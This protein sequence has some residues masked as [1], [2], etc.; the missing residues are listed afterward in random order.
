MIQ[1][2]YL[3]TRQAEFS[4]SNAARIAT[5]PFVAKKKSF[6]DLMANEHCV[7]CFLVLHAY[8]THFLAMLLQEFASFPNC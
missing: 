4:L 2:H 3:I 1:C 5:C 7:R 6:L 8:A